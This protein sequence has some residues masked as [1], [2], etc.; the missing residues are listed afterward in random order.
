MRY[1][2]LDIDKG[3][4]VTK[5]K[6]VVRM[7]GSGGSGMG[8]TVRGNQVLARFSSAVSVMSRLW[9]VPFLYSTGGKPVLRERE[10]CSQ[11]TV[12]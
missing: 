1:R 6:V 7:V 3:G 12:Q 10:L 8:E 11:V 4:T 9:Q 5:G 2:Q